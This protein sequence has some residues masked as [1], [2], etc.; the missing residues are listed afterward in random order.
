V[1]VGNGSGTVGSG[2]KM[3]VPVGGGFG[4]SD[5]PVVVG[6]PVG[7]GVGVFFA[8]TTDTSV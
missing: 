3:I 6:L 5:V 7:N 1:V 2:V 4:L 8:G